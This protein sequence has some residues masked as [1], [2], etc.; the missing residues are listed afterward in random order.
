MEWIR[1]IHRLLHH[2]H[3]VWT[4]TPQANAA[5]ALIAA[6]LFIKTITLYP[7]AGSR[8]Y[9]GFLLGMSVGFFFGAYWYHAFSTHWSF[10]RR[11]YSVKT[12]TR[13]RLK[14]LYKKTDYEIPSYIA[15]VIFG[16]I[17][18]YISVNSFIWLASGMFFGFI[19]GGSLA[20][21]V[22]LKYLA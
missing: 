15:A 19:F 11:F 2:E 13:D 14:M 8:I 5:T 7:G 10:Y 9:A 21:A 4:M 20:L 16:F 1:K 18:V 6:L 3:L 17:L 12:K 22:V